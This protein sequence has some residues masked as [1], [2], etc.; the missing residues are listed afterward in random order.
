[1]QCWCSWGIQSLIGLLLGLPIA[2]HSWGYFQRPAP[3]PLS[4]NLAPGAIYERRILTTPR[5][6]VV[7][8]VKIDLTYPQLKLLVTPGTPGADGNE[9]NALTTREFLQRYNQDLAVNASFFYPFREAAPWNYYPRSGDRT[10]AVGYAASG[11]QVYSSGAVPTWPVICFDAQN[12]AQI[13]AQPNCP[14]GTVNGLSGNEL[15]LQNGEPLSNASPKDKAYPRTIVATDN[16]GK[17][18]WL[19]VIDGKQPWYSEGM[20]IAQTVPLLQQLGVSQALNLDGGGSVS[21]VQAVQGQARLL[22]APIQNKIPMTERPIANHLGLSWSGQ[23][24]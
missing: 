7:H 21:L 2:L 8:I 10:N 1:M 11:G 16:S 24:Q 6:N 12:Q 17:T 9:L 18:L 19:I 4:V 23:A 15:I 3:V 20:T 22:N 13:L 14:S 5:P